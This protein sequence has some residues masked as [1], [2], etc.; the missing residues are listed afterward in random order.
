MTQARRLRWPLRALLS[1]AA[2]L[3][4]PAGAQALRDGDI[5][6][7][8]SRSSQSLA[9][10][11]ATHSRYSHMGM[12]VHRDG[13]PQ[14]LEAA[15]TVRYTPLAQWKASGR[16]G[17]IVVKRL[18]DADARLDAATTQRLVASAH[19]FVGRPYDL[20]FGWSDERLY[21]SELVW[22][23]YAEALD[24]QI[25]TLQR[26]VDLDLSDPA[27]QAKLHERYGAQV[28]LHE[29]VISPAAMFDSPLLR[30]VGD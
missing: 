2:L 20:A 26:L 10:Q 25:G 11:R 19:Q 3:A 23:A 12:I 27:V 8:T 9:V 30:T 28:P 1:A 24:V 5:V 29:Q 13:M 18:H 6:F 22:K 14:V 21:C 7:Q 17:H 16:D 4:L 15:A